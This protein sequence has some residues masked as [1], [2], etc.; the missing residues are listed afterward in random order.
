MSRSKL[1][2]HLG[3]SWLE[4]PFL[5]DQF[6]QRV[7]PALGCTRQKLREAIC[8]ALGLDE[9]EGLGRVSRIMAQVYELLVTVHQDMDIEHEG[10]DRE[11]TGLAAAVVRAWRNDGEDMSGLQDVDENTIEPI[12]TLPWREWA[13]WR[14]GSGDGETGAFDGEAEG[15]DQEQAYAVLDDVMVSCHQWREDILNSY[16]I[17]QE[18]TPVGLNA[19]DAAAA[20]I[21]QVS[22]I[23]ERK[24]LDLRLGSVLRERGFQTIAFAGMVEYLERTVP[25]EK[26]QLRGWLLNRHEGLLA[27]MDIGDNVVQVRELRKHFR[28]MGPGW[29]TAPTK[30][31]RAC[32]KC[33]PT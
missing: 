31:A 6:V 27:R 22:P 17:V 19:L 29:S 25:P 20:L 9:Y 24:M 2:N 12:K 4:L 5:V 26:L 23:Q 28:W 13:A 11:R 10:V 8:V 16:T 33:W 14:E 21:A 32:G 30:T 15:G 1:N 7:A 18:G 3:Q